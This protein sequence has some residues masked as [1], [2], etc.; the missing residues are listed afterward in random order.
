M[1]ALLLVGEPFSPESETLQNVTMH[2][3]ALRHGLN[4]YAQTLFTM[5]PAW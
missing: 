2:T 1:K 5:L 4:P 3:A